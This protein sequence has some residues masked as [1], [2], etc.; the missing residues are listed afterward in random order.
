MHGLGYGGWGWLLLGL[1]L[2]AAGCSKGDTDRL[3]RVGRK[4]LAKAASLSEDTNDRLHTGWQS[5]RGNLGE[6]GLDAR[7]ATRLRWDK[8]LAETPI[9]V[10]AL[11]DNA[12]EL[13]GPVADLD[14]RRRA[15]ALAESTLGVERVVDSLE[16]PGSDR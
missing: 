8:T 1:G 14:Q 4:V 13:K 2:L 11:P 15:V 12:V 9:E 5:F 3:A 6:T 16:M 7:V 10:M